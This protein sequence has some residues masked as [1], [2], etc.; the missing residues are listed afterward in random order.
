MQIHPYISGHWR[1][2]HDIPDRQ[3]ETLLKLLWIENPGY[4]HL[5]ARLVERQYYEIAFALKVNKADNL[6][7]AHRQYVQTVKRIIKQCLGAAPIGYD[8]S[9]PIRM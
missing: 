3:I 6:S 2:P 8:I 1:I 5:Y 7:K 9:A 4:E